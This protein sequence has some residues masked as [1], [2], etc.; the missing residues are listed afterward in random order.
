MAMPLETPISSRPKRRRYRPDPKRR[1]DGRSHTAQAIKRLVSQWTQRLSSH[2]P[3]SPA[4]IEAMRR[5]AQLVVLASECRVRAMQGAPVLDDLV[6]LERLSD[7]AVRRLG[8]PEE[9]PPGALPRGVSPEELATG[10][11]W[12]REAMMEPDPHA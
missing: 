6:R 4:K 7:L 3:V 5:A 10:P 9:V 2:A 1:I 12:W 8:I 11:K